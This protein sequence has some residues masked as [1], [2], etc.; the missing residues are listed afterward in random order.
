[1]FVFATWN[2]A[3][4]NVSEMNYMIHTVDSWIFHHYVA[5]SS[6]HYKILEIQLLWNSDM[7]SLVI[8]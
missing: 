6:K 4:V 8:Y 5:I 1:M 7:M 2:I 3:N